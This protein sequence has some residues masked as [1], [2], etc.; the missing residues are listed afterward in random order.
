[1]AELFSEIYN[2]YFQVVKTLIESNKAISMSETEH[3]IKY[4]GFEVLETYGDFKGTEFGKTPYA[5][6]IIMFSKVKER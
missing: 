2:C 1:M 6:D 3:R 5:G 4:M